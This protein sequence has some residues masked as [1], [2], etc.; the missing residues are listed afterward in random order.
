[1]SVAAIFVFARHR[2]VCHSQ[3]QMPIELRSM[4][5][6]ADE[7]HP[8]PSKSELDKLERGS[9][10]KV[11]DPEGNIWYWVV[12]QKRLKDDKH[13]FVGRIDAHCVIGPTLRHGGTIIFHEDNVLFIWPRK[14]DAVFDKTWFRILSDLISLGA[15]VKAI[16]RG[17]NR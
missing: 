10:V 16:K 13:Y 8:P 6:R 14:V 5:G 1:L 17:T 7:T 4:D 15:G 3:K 2:Q 9:M 12:I 11:F